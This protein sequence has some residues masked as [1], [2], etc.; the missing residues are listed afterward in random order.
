MTTHVFAEGVKIHYFCFALVCE[1]GLSF[2]C[3]R[4]IAADWNNLKVQS[5]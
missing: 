3:V 2:E 1:I 4:P 5:R